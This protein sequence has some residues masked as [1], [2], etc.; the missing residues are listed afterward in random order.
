MNIKIEFNQSFLI[1]V[2]S[3]SVCYTTLFCWIS[4]VCPHDPL[5]AINVCA[6]SLSVIIVHGGNLIILLYCLFT[7][8]SVSHFGLGSMPSDM[9]LLNYLIEDFHSA[10]F[11]TTLLTFSLGL[12]GWMFDTFLLLFY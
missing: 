12:S 7:V 9:Y 11:N 10:V 3:T 2:N 6:Q 5:F 4:Y 1:C 8:V